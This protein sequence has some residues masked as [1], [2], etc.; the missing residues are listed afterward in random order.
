MSPSEPRSVYEFGDDPV[1]HREVIADERRDHAHAEARGQR[2]L[3][4]ADQLIDELLGAGVP[5]RRPVLRPLFFRVLADDIYR[6]AA[7]D[8][9]D[10][11]ESPAQAERTGDA[12]D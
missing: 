4:L 12:S 11:V 9:P 3:H 8:I 2:V 1:R 6:N 10:M 5:A 7:I